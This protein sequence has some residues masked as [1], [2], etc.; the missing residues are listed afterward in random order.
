MTTREASCCCGQL[1]LTTAGEP[2]RISICHCLECQR[3][4]G[5]VFG[6][7]ARFKRAQVTIEGRTVEY[8]RKG[9]SGDPITFRFC[10]A[11]GSTVYWTLSALP[12]LIAVAVGAFADPGFPAPRV[13]VYE[14]RRHPWVGMPET[15]GERVD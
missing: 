3:R 10:P 7:Q 11:C 14:Q 1:R 6:T 15:I 2:V 8:V 5:S 13:S 9:D 4:T 12:E